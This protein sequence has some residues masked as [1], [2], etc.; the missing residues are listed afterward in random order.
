[1]TIDYQSLSFPNSTFIFRF[2][3]S[4]LFQ[5]YNLMKTINAINTSLNNNPLIEQ[6]STT[7]MFSISSLKK[8]YCCFLLM[9]GLICLKD[10]IG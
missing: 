2:Y 8:F 3:V 7:I 1:M 5:K 6:P 9:H 4:I 10:L